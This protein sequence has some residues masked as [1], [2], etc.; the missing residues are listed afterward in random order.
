MR[1]PQPKTPFHALQLLEAGD[2]E[3]VED[4]GVDGMPMWPFFNCHSGRCC[5]V[6]ALAI[7]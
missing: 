2:F 4:V 6:V 5:S 3:L 1:S 7:L